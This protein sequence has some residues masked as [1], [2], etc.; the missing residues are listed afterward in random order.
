MQDYKLNVLFNQ[1]IPLLVEWGTTNGRWG[2]LGYRDVVQ[3]VRGY[4]MFG[5]RDK[6]LMRLDQTLSH[7]YSSGHAVRSFPTVHEDSTMRYVDSSR[8]LVGTVTEYLK[9]TG[10]MGGGVGAVRELREEVCQ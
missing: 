5:R 7:Q 9:E 10:D 8:W 6:V 1:W 4:M 2:M 3:Q